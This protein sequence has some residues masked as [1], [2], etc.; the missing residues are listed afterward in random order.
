MN[1]LQAY[2]GTAAGFAY[3]FVKAPSF[4]AIFLFPV[5]YQPTVALTLGVFICCEF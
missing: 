2:R 4:L 5:L 3:I 1:G